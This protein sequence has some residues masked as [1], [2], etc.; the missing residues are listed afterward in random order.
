M[1]L[2]IHP[3]NCIR[4]WILAISL[5]L[6]VNS[7]GIVLGAQTAPEPRREELLNGLRV[8]IWT[9]PASE[10]VTITL[11]IHSG[12]AFDLAGKAGTM[13]L[14]SDQLFPD[15]ET[16][17]FFVDELG[18][19]LQVTVGYDATEIQIT[20]RA[21]EFER[22]LEIL[23]TA[24]IS[25]SI[26][27]DT[28]ARLRA[29]RIKMSR[30]LSAGPSFIADLAIAN[31]LFGDFP[32]GRSIGGTPETLARIDRADL[33]MARER[34]H[35]PDNA[36][37]AVIGGVQESRALRAL[38]QLL[39]AWRK[40][41]K[42]V[43]ATFRMADPPDA[44]TL[45][46]DMPGSEGVEIRLAT[47]SVSRADK[48]YTI[49]ALVALLALNR[50]QAG[51]PESSRN[52]VS[53]RNESYLLSGMFVMGAAVPST[54]AAKVLESARATLRTLI[55]SPPSV[56]EMERVRNELATLIGKGSN[57]PASIA[58]MWLDAESYKLS[59]NSDPM[60][61]LSKITPADIQRVAT[62]LFRDATFASIAVGSASLI[63][64]EFE[65]AGKVDVL[66]ERIETKSSDNKT[67]EKTP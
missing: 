47:R 28:V 48:D 25:T 2:R 32:Y 50:W 63:K 14:L 51:F 59:S 44:S 46:V 34:F 39:G 58:K 23:R 35:T 38:R 29:A 49:A 7:T 52:A 19:S 16:R 9:Q 10:S 42:L 31:R 54:G 43:P 21:S 15:P 17:E 3:S 67:P 40:S 6:I 37:L 56:V 26:P 5:F 60:R 64:P 36:T 12:A 30:D 62:R 18:G 33:M 4:T 45:I 61:S 24:L 1:I 41:D 20:G 8:L 13:A 57:E 55:N 66:G 22:M 53:V 65:R 27:G 11:R